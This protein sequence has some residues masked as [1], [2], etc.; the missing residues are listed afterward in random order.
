MIVKTV[1]KDAV[2]TEL[3]EGSKQFCIR[4]LMFIKNGIF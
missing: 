3:E 2:G 1:E 4:K